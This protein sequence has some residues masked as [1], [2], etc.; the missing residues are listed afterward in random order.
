MKP[1]RHFSSAIV[2]G[3]NML[4]TPS[5]SV[6]LSDNMVLSPDGLCKTFD[7]N[8]NGY[9]RGEAVNAVY[10]KTLDK[11]IADGDPIRAVIRAT[12]ANYDGRTAKIFAPDIAGQERLIRKAYE[13]AQIDN[14]AE[15]A[16]VECHGTGT[17]RGDMVEATAI[18]QT[19]HPHGVHIGSVSTKP[20]CDA[21]L[22][23]PLTRSR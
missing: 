16:F 19:F 6:T 9:A 23:I 22:G 1:A 21:V 20:C 3:T 18:A 11:A 10:I 15:T 7:A 8:A 4:L 14:I 5:M 17:R 12:S 13:R 2:A